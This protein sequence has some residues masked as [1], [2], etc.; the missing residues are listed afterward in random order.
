LRGGASL[1]CEAQ[2]ESQPGRQSHPLRIC[3]A[4]HSFAMN[5]Y[6]PRRQYA[7]PPVRD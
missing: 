1:K 7:G 3:E 5:N 2:M 4:D 6:A